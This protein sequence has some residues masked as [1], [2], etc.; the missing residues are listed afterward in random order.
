MRYE[1]SVVPFGA[2]PHLS[3]LEAL[4]GRGIAV[5]HH[6]RLE[7]ALP[8]GSTRFW[9]RV[10]DA[11]GSLISGF[12][13]TRFWNRTV[14]GARSI[15]IERFGRALHEPIHRDAGT[16]FK[17]LAQQHR[18]L[19]RVLVE[20][21]DEDG[22]RRDVAVQSLLEQGGLP[23]EHTRN[24]SETLSVDLQGSPDEIFA[25]FSSSTRRNIR[26]VEKSGAT[27]VEVTDPRYLPRLAEL[28]AQSFERTGA[29]PPHADFAAIQR[30]AE[31]GKHAILLGCIWPTRTPPNDLVAFVWGRSHGD[32]GSYDIG[33]SERAPDLGRVPLIYP[34]LWNLIQWSK[35]S[36]H[37]WFDLGGVIPADAPEDHP[38]RGISAFKMGFTD[39]RVAISSEVWIEPNRVL[40]GVSERIK[41]LRK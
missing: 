15:R 31:N 37:S 12:A 29:V 13:F 8:R 40:S 5:P 38:L 27:I 3:D 7:D 9:C 19:L 10:L 20:L 6:Y 30:E 22:V 39:R 17:A 26:S 34:L 4:A 36:A 25:R 32:H 28:Y 24:Y 14:P 18:L 16:V 35:R 41:T 33:A 23:Q 11:N 2:A 21:F 1:L